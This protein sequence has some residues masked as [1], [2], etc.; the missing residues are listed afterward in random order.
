M[1][2]FRIFLLIL[3]IIGLALIFTQ[4]IWVPKLVD[5]ILSSEK[6]PVVISVVQPT[7]G[8]LVIYNNPDYGFTFS[9]PAD[10]KGYSIVQTTWHG[11]PFTNGTPITNNTSNET[12]PTLSIR[13][14]NWT[15]DNHYEDIPILVFTIAQWNSYL[16]GDFVVSAAP[17]PAMEL[18]RNN[19]YVFALPPRWDYD[20]SQGYQEAENI[21]STK[22]LH[23]FNL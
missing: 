4:K 23:P 9:L 20:F 12:G 6:I 16:A 19:F 21:L 15:S 3:I 14:P 11:T 17:I 7:N 2:T 22:P 18:A 8:S 10:W 13:N 1:K 5:Q